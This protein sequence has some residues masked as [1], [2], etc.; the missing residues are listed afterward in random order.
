MIVFS[1]ESGNRKVISISIAFGS[2]APEFASWRR[3]GS[4]ARRSATRSSLLLCTVSTATFVSDA[5][6]FSIPTS[7][8]R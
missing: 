4:I 6:D 2:A 5:N 8:S 1:A 3:I 7:A